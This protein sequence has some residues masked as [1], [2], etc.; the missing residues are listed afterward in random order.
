MKLAQDGAKGVVLMLN[1]LSGEV[2]HV[3]GAKTIGNGRDAKVQLW[4]EQQQMD[5]DLW[6]NQGTWEGKWISF[7]RIQ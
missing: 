6:F 1:P 4:D 2:G 7:F 5:G 3:I